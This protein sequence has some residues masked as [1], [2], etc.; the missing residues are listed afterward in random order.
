M[1][2]LQEDF[3]LEEFRQLHEH[4]RTF[5][6]GIAAFF[7]PSIIANFTG[8]AG[9]LGFYLSHTDRSSLGIWYPYLFLGPAALSIL[10]LSI[11]NMYRTSIYRMG[12]YIQVFFEE[13]LGGAQWHVR[14]KSYRTRVSGRYIEPIAFACWA[15]MVTALL[16]FGTIL[17][18]QGARS[19]WHA[20]VTVPFLL[21]MGAQHKRF[22]NKEDVEAVWLSLKTL[23]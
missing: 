16:L 2:T 7:T 15:M 6:A 3:A 1:A 21:A 17:F 11:I 5:E 19:W 13:A 18:A 22:A 10:T 23:P 4:I 9:I 20:A 8:I 14:L 12:H